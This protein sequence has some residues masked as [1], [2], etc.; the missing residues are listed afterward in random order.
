MTGASI[1]DALVERGL[2]AAEKQAKTRPFDRALGALGGPAAHA[3]WVPGRLEV[4]GKHTDYAGGRSLVCA[5]PRGLALVARPRTDAQVR[6]VAADG[7]TA[8]HRYTDTVV[9]RLA[10]NFRESPHGVHMAFA[11]D[12]P[13]ASGM[14]SSSAL[15]VG[16]AAALVHFRQLERTAPW[17][18]NIPDALAASGYYACIENGM[19][20]GT[21]DGDAGV[22]THGGSE[23]HAAIVTGVVGE[24]SAFAFV[25]LRLLDRVAFPAGWSF[26]IATSRTRAEKTGGAQGSYNRLSDEAR[27]LL[28]LWNRHHQPAA[29][30]S[31]ALSSS[32]DAV[33]TLHALI[34]ADWRQSLHARLD[35]FISEDARVPA[36]VEAF[37]TGDAAA[38]SQLSS[39]SQHD[40]DVLLA[41]QIDETR[42]LASY[43]HAH[44]AFAACSFGA[45]F[46]GSVWALVESG[47]ARSFAESW[48]PGAFVM[49]PSLALTHITSA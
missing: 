46:G 10:R 20:Y 25:P 32:S 1:A 6:V 19:S 11:S 3:W 41:N 35:H 16:I 33:N 30:L 4:F 22:G 44:G 42:T 34:D 27:E 17:R 8:F 37:R 26:V 31:A 7:S 18:D 49:R 2:D 28:A 36:G 13:D 38:L 9:R 14:S 47:R 12:L 43:A 24:L 5:V 48:H 21:L 45:G 39:A 23:D 40:A 29:S 15:V